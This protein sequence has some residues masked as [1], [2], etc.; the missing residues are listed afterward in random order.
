[1][2]NALNYFHL[3]QLP[4]SL[5]TLLTTTLAYCVTVVLTFDFVDQITIQMGFNE[6]PT[7]QKATCFDWM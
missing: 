3:K 1:M 2:D 4:A 7:A 6:T 5:V